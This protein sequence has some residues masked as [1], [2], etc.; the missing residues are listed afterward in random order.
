[1]DGRDAQG[2]PARCAGARRA[3]HRGQDAGAGAVIRAG[4]IRL[5]VRGSHQRANQV[6]GQ[7]GGDPPPARPGTP[8][9]PHSSSTSSALAAISACSHASP[10]RPGDEQLSSR[11]L[12]AQRSAG[13]AGLL[14]SARPGL[15]RPPPPPPHPLKKPRPTAASSTMCPTCTTHCTHTLT[16]TTWACPASQPSSR[17]GQGGGA[18]ALLRGHVRAPAELQARMLHQAMRH[19][20]TRRCA[21][22]PPGDAPRLH[23]AMRHASTRRCATPPSAAGLPRRRVTLLP[24][25]LAGGVRRGARAR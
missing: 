19:A 8:L 25:P 15:S 17:C 1:L 18:A 7:A 12:R 16:A 3:S 13:G 14:A 4:V 21:T 10:A 11:V 22:P 6:R 24:P 20:S 5:Q 9:P 23:Q 2:A